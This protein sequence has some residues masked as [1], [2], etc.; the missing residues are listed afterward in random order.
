MTDNTAKGKE[1]QWVHFKSTSYVLVLFLD[2]DEN[3]IS[4]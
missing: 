4:V 2:L 1:R 3:I